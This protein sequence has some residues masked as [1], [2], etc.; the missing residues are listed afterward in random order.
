MPRN[1]VDQAQQHFFQI[2]CNF[3]T[4][5]SVCII[6]CVALCGGFLARVSAGTLARLRQVFACR[7][8]KSDARLAAKARHGSDRGFHI[9]QYIL[10]CGGFLINKYGSSIMGP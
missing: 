9:I 6:R 1:H 3:Q 5:P 7:R 2:P 8:E 4:Y 10:V